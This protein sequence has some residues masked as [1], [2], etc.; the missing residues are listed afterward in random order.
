MNK[1]TFITV[2]T[3]FDG[4]HCWAN[5]PHEEVAF[6]RN[7]HRHV[8]WVRLEVEVFSD[9][10]D[11][12]YF[13]IK[14]KLDNAINELYG[15]GNTSSNIKLLGSKSCEMINDDIY[16]NLFVGPL[17]PMSQD[18]GQRQVSI[19]TSEDDENSATTRYV[20]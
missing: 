15:N 11:L 19:T 3:S 8:F 13:M 18:K 20:R 12:E 2:K 1:Q 9:D 16:K 17:A 10:R 14:R 6:L 5:C 4:I 7:P